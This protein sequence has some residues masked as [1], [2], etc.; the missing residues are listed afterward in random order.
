M[1]WK[2]YIFFTFNP[3][4]LKVNPSWG[5]QINKQTNKKTKT[6]NKNKKYTKQ[7]ENINPNTRK[8]NNVWCQGFVLLVPRRQQLEF[9][10]YLKG[11]PESY[12][13]L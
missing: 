11:I 6:K 2:L 5:K 8:L 4:E 9:K 7:T 10:D 12:L 1:K 3:G 13:N